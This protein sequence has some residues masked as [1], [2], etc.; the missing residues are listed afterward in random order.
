MRSGCRDLSSHYELL[1]RISE[2]SFGCVYR[3]RSK[4]SGRIL[5]SAEIDV[6]ERDVFTMQAL[7]SFKVP[8][9]LEAEGF[10]TSTLREISSLLSLTHP[11]VIE[12]VE[13]VADKN[14]KV[15]MVGRKCLTELVE[16]Q[17]AGDGVYRTRAWGSTAKQETRVLLI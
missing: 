8:E 9:K 13:V 10:P 16:L 15:F 3:G 11:N 17:V 6:D 14:Q 12:V 4:E 7:K 2:G 1:N 5:V